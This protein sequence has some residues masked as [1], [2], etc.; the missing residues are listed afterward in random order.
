[1][2]G[3]GY[4]LIDKAGTIYYNCNYRGYEFQFEAPAEEIEQVEI[5]SYSYESHDDNGQGIGDLILYKIPRWQSK[6]NSVSE[7]TIESYFN[8]NISGSN[9]LKTWFATTQ[10][11]AFED[12]E[13]YEN[14]QAIKDYYSEVD[15]EQTDEEG[16][17]KPVNECLEKV[18][19]TNIDGKLM[20][21]K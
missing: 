5:D 6:D 7:S 4:G 13:F 18:I 15:F 2:D 12:V 16:N 9:E 14:E 11:E 17:I 21:I 1:M 19:R 20:V 8:N 3:L 10:G